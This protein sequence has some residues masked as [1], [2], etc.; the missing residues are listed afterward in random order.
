M[1]NQQPQN[2][3]NPDTPDSLSA[4]EW[5][6]KEPSDKSV[7]DG[8]TDNNDF[9]NDYVKVPS[10]GDPSP[11]SN[12]LDMHDIIQ[13]AIEA[14]ADERVSEEEARRQTSMAVGQIATSL[15]LTD[16]DI[17]NLNAYGQYK[18]PELDTDD[19]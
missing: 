1:N 16:E 2:F 18:I 3:N 10:D 19:H 7:D 15:G 9:G 8:V 17:K 14:E 4:N 13:Q 5:L 11:I 6:P 12:Q